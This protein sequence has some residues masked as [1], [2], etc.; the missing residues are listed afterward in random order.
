MRALHIVGKVV[1]WIA[2]SALL[3]VVATLLTVIV[4]GR[5]DWGHRK[6]LAI[7]LPELQK[8]LAGHLTIGAIEGDLT[9]GLS[10]RD[11]ELDD[12]E[13]LPAVRI[14][15]L[16]VHYN[17]LGLLHH[18]ID[19]TELKAEQA[20]VHA[21][22]LRD[23]TLNLATLAKPSDK[24]EQ[25]QKQSSSGYKVRLGKVWAELEGRYDRP[26]TADSP[27]QRIYGNAHL[28]AHATIANGKIDAG[29]DELDVA[30]LLPLRARLTAK[31]GVTIDNGAVAAHGFELALTS[32]GRELRR[33]A[34]TVALRGR[35]NVELEA[36]G[37]A[38]KLALSV[39]ARP[40][41]GRLA[42]DAQLETGA[43]LAWSGTI[44][45]RGI[46]PAAA[47]AG[48]PHGDVRVDAS[49]RGQGAHGTIDL[50]ALVA[51]VAGTRVDA[52]GRLDTAGDARIMANVASRDLSELR[53][54][55]VRGLAGSV[56][57]RARIE[58]TRSHLH[59]DADVSAQHLVVQ[60]NRV[61]TLDAHVHD[62]DLIGEAHVA[63]AGIKAGGVQLDTLTLD[64]KGDRNA[65]QA[66]LQ[67]KGPDATTLALALHGTPTVVRH[68]GSSGVKIVGAD[69]SVDKLALARH[70][71][72]WQSAGPATLRVHDGV[73]LQGLELSSG[74]QRLGLDARYEA[75][76]T[77]MTVSLRAQKLDLKR[78]VG[79]VKPSIDLPST[80]LAIDARVRGTKKR[81]VVEVSLDGFSVRSQRLGLNRIHYKLDARYA[82][83]RAKAQWKLSALDQSFQGKID[84]PTVMTGNRPIMA[85][86]AASNI[87]MVKLQ[88]VLPPAIANLDGRLD[89]S[90]K[91]S[92]TTERPVL[93]VDLHGRKWSLGPDDK[94]NDV[95]MSVDYKER[96]LNARVDVHLQQSM[97]KDAGALTAQL[98][99]PIDAA[100]DRLQHAERLVDQL[101]HKTPIA[102]VVNLIKVDLAKVPFV[103]LGMTPPVTAG[104]V[105]GS[106]KLRG[107]LHEPNLDVDVEGHQLARGKVD[108]ID[109]FASLDYADKKASM[110]VDASL[111]GAPLLRVRGESP[112]DL[113]RVL[114]HEPYRETPLHV[115]AEVPGFNLV[116]VQD[117]VPKIEGQVNGKAE[118]RGTIARPTGTL[119]LAIAALNLGAMKYDKFEAN[120]RFDG[121]NV[122]A[123]LDAH[124]V[125]GGAV[126]ADATLPVDAKAPLSAALRAHG[127]YID[128]ENVSLTNPR[129]FKGT[130]E[131]S[132]DVRGPRANPTVQ[133]FVKLADGELALAG[134]PR[135]YEDV[136]LDVAIANGVVTLKNAHAKVQDGTVT[137]S[138]QAKL[139]GAKPQSVD[140]QAEAHKFPIPT[141]TF[142]AWLDAKVSVHGA[143]T[144]DGMSGTIVVEKGTANLPKL[145]G[146]KKLQSTGPLEDVKFVDAGARRAAAKRAQAEKQPAT[147]ELV[148]KI[149]GPFHVRSKELST[150]L[151]GEVQVA[152]VGP[153]VRLTGKMQTHGGWIELL[154][155]RYNIEKARVGFGGESEPD[156]ELD[157]RLTRE[158][159]QTVLII[160]VHGTAKKPTL[161]LTCDPPIY[162]QSEVIAAILSGDPATQ[163]VD[164]RSLDQKVTGAVSGLLVGKIKDQ[165]APNLPID[166]IKVDTGSEGSTGLGDTRVEVGKYIT[167]TV[168]VSYVH[169]FGT[170][171]VGTQ[172]FNSNEADLEWRFKKRYELETA[173]GDAAVGRVNLYWT[174]RY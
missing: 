55:G 46:D 53:A 99:L 43:A 62:E 4:V 34:P 7:A 3:L 134:D 151:S 174:I 11:V 13:H 146:G 111:R 158:L 20:W 108:K 130:L 96:K 48:A 61:G 115:D 129:L 32:E 86:I 147:T 167:D 135:V 38:D 66:S 131:A 126:T 101:E 58:R 127:F 94:N 79:L 124:E 10:L 41:A 92:G 168:Y 56:N 88:K 132:V 113:E 69:L 93:A 122:V 170:T 24:K 14:K 106:L 159:S 149:P 22:V 77:A 118:V 133:G 155:R 169:Q 156:P 83:D 23:G 51:S 5:T 98:E 153:V 100:L 123:K 162:D 39:V 6:M 45:A 47:V 65:V 173:F 95:R 165:I 107:T 163:R 164:D 44:E 31:G 27:A 89:G 63:A 161:L 97:G 110:K 75:R 112:L 30:T 26:A 15:A 142:G 59:V 154:G 157:V 9:H 90:I 84:V 82:D 73:E 121:K 145:E 40:P 144:P 114:D 141:G 52:H 128:L 120:A 36:N 104:I 18:T 116:R 28:E 140:L 119:A 105:D 81:P 21:R 42:L 19:L 12:V 33:L 139:V 117:L 76:S 74:A 102:A 72:T 35:W 37:P 171:F 71:Q 148:A 166:V 29:L 87:W 2:L 49:G 8:Q 68:H 160:E 67:G 137:A 143:T 125:K 172:Q 80:E 64:A 60:Q 109:L 136:A 91:A 54:L 138:G 103:E 70:G 78:L 17:L 85:D 150:D 50:K 16:T 152:I 57:A 1:G 25:R